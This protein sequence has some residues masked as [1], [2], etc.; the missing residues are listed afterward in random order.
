MSARFPIVAVTGSSGAGTSST[1]AL[2][3]RLFARLGLRAAFVEGDSFHAYDRAQMRA[4]LERARIRAENFSHFG[5]AANLWDRLERLFADFGERGQGS[6]RSYLHTEE[7]ARAARAAVGTFTP[8]ASLPAGTELLFYEG[9]HAGVVTPEHDLASH[10]DLLIGMTP[11]IN[12]EWTQKMHRD[13]AERG[14]DAAEVTRTILRRMPD[15]VHY[16]IP[17]FSRTDVNFQRVPLVD[18]SHPFTLSEIPRAEDS[19]VVIHLNRHARIPVALAQLR[20][21]LPG[22]F[23][24]RPD[25]LVVPG[26]QMEA[27]MEQVLWPALQRL[28]DARRLAA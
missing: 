12:L 20:D 23:L 24:S 11:T 19:L 13:T 15:Y 6:V 7:E 10:V 3:A 28:A 5:P 4:V 25:T 18:T 1:R 9:L 2:F 16:L 17:Q 8:W 26:V 27:A 21:A 22:A 14:H